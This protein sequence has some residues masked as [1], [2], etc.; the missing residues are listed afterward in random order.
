MESSRKGWELLDAAKFLTAPEKWMWDES[1]DGVIASSDHHAV[2]FENEFIR[3]LEICIEP[4]EKEDFHTHSRNSIMIIDSAVDMRYYGAD[5]N[6]KFERKIPR[7]VSQKTS[8]VW[9]DPEGLHSIENIDTRVFHGVR[10]E[11]KGR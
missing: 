4:G 1:Y 2:M 5:G 7:D 3:V 6:I 10:I 8:I 9:R 11:L